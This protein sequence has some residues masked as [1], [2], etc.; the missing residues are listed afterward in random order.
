[1]PKY[2]EVIYWL[3]LI[4]ESGLK[5]NLVKPIVQ[6]WCLGEKRL[7]ADLFD[8]SPLEVSTTFGLAD[9]EAK[10]IVGAADKLAAQ[11][12]T[13]TQWQAEG[14]EP[15]IR[16]DSRY[17]K[18][19][20]Q[21][22]PPAKQPL[23]LW[24]RG[25]VSLLNRPG[26]TMLGRTD[27]DETTANFIDE[28][29]ATLEAEEVGLISGYGR[30]LDRMTFEAMLATEN[31]YAVTMLPLGLSAFAKTTSKL[32]G[33]V[34]SGRTVLVS[35]FAPDSPFQEKLAEARNLLID[36]LTLALLIP[37]SD[38]EAQVRATAALNRGLPVFVKADTVGNRA[39]LNQGALLLTDPGEVVEW[40]QQAIID[41]AM[42]E[43]E[44]ET[45]SEDWTAAPLIS[46][47]P[48][49][50][51][52]PDDDYSLRGEETPPLD[53]DEAMEVLSLGGEIP[54]VLR[55]RLQKSKGDE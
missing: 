13:L 44:D 24:V 31:G 48:T 30:G 14:L 49:E 5:L 52:I 55:Q 36:H 29:M 37:E 11:A 19:L 54:E 39:L 27:L 51:P 9:E 10:R 43:A 26:V 20:A 35:P 18:R 7:L 2:P 25:P 23:V 40:V 38:E 46:T 50:P 17:P 53:S 4:N 22:L 41:M 32:E 33:A 1:M 12:A 3:T 16:I 21:N 45:S 42:Q 34:E 28:L 47:A 15:L 6:R 8:L